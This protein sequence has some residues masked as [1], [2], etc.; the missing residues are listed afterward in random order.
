[1]DSRRPVAQLVAPLGLFLASGVLLCLAGCED[2]ARNVASHRPPVIQAVTVAQPTTVPQARTIPQS[3]AAQQAGTVQQPSP[4]MKAPGVKAA[5][6]IGVLPL[7]PSRG[8]TAFLALL[9]P[10]AV[11]RLADQ[12]RAL[13]AAGEQEAKADR[14][15]AAQQDY[16]RAL[17]LLL[18]SGFDLGREPALSGLFNQVMFSLS[19]VQSST[20][21]AEA[22]EVP[23]AEQQSRPSPLDQITAIT[24]LS[25]E[26]IPAAP[27]DAGLKTNAERELQAVPHDLPLTLTDPVLSFLNFF[28]TARGRAIVE[29]GLRR[30]GRYRDMIRRVLA[31]EGMPSDLIY[32]AQAES[33]FEPQ[34]LSRAGARGLWQFM[35]YRG[36]QYGL[37]HSWWLDERQDPEKATRAA[38]HHLRDLYEMFGDWYLV[39][40][41]YNSGPGTVQHAVERTGYADF[42]ELY[43]LNVLPQETRNYVPIILALTLISKD[44]ARYGIEFV[45]D[46]PLQVDRVQPGHPV[47]LRLVSETIDVDVD[48]LRLLNPQLLRLATPNDPRFAL[49]IPAGKAEEFEKGMAEIPPEN[50]VNWRRH[51]V[52]EGETLS[53][54]A[55]RYRIS[56][57]SLAEVNG[58]DAQARPAVN[59]KLII[60]ATA[61]AQP[62]L[63]AL[64]RYRA[65][66]GDTVESV[67]DQFNVTVAELKKWN[68]MRGNHLVAGMRLRIYPGVTG[69]GPGVAGPAPVRASVTAARVETPA[70]A[71]QPV[72]HRVRQGETLWSIAQAYQTTIEALRS[73]NRFL[74]SRP[75]QAGDVLTIVQSH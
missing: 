69:P 50:W 25:G 43:K 35:S 11:T 38:A 31:E 67:A 46:Q 30:A 24:A 61:Q 29:N 73:G 13:F 58:L 15:E 6:R 66:H 2:S 26:E 17:D 14:N 60:P 40:A 64:V 7:G 51:R 57:A 42:W 10:D 56:V 52:E 44:P 32:L 54:I 21:G 1:M 55:R 48:T 63:G 36:K 62:T 5:P 33:A 9:S 20:Q 19:L 41:A 53:S 3:T 71:G 8:H 37:E 47:D 34:A 49:R 68:G 39:M 4:G 27:A 72:I 65:R 18:A 45:P 23:P 22:S 74:F 70:K 75:L 16:D 28:Q 12:V 59:T